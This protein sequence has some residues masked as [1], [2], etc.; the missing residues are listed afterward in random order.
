MAS[1]HMFPEAL[2][3]LCMQPLHV[4]AIRGSKD[5]VVELLAAGLTADTRSARGW[6]PLLE[7]ADARHREVALELARAEVMQVRLWRGLGMLVAM[8]AVCVLMLMGF[9]C[10]ATLSVLVL[11]P[12]PRAR[13]TICVHAPA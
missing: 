4:A 5:A 11:M 3:S 9:T 13:L 10:R 6:V 7:A 8:H 1:E 2:H 12:C